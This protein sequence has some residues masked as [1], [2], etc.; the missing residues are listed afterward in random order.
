MLRIEELPHDYTRH[1][2]DCD[3]W[4]QKPSRLVGARNSQSAQ[5]N[6]TDRA[7]RTDHVVPNGNVDRSESDLSQNTHARVTTF[8]RR[9]AR[10]SIRPR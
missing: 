9:D 8:V 10:T 6:P 7:H 2:A 5:P 1:S 4:Q 3:F